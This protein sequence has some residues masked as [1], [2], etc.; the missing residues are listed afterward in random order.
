MLGFAPQNLHSSFRRVSEIL[1][2]ENTEA[3]KTKCLDHD[4]LASK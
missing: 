4:L 2:G 1:M 3:Q